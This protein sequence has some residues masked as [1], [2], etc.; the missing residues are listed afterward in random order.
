MSAPVLIALGV[1]AVLAAACGGST[2]TAAST[3]TSLPPV[4]APSP[5]HWAP[6][7]AS[8]TEQCGTVPVPVDYAH[9]GG[10]SLS[11][12]VAEIPASGPGTPLGDLVFN[13]G[14]PGESGVGLLPVIAGSLPKAVT[15]RFAIVGFD[16]L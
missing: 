12:A 16:E 7:P 6:C 9:P 2:T 15:D 4:P 1:T 5:I 10:P 14:G 13:P 11:L 8:T 3:S